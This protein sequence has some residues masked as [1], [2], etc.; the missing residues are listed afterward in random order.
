[1]SFPPPQPGQVIRYSYLWKDE[2]AAGQVE[3]RKDGPVA[4]V[5]VLGAGTPTPEVVV[6]PITHHPRAD[7]VCVRIPV[8]TARRLGL[9][10]EAQWVVANEANKFFW[11][12]PD[13]RPKPGEGP[14]SIFI[15]MMPSGFM[16]M[17]RDAAV[18]ALQGGI[19]QRSA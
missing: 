8:P 4:V 12:G 9:D 17:V 10:S 14:A 13:L 3:G 16:T 1:V 19:V 2:D 6:C 7:A 5:L 18:R 11:P 15:G